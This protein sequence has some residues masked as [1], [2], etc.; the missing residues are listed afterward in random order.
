[1]RNSLLILG[2]TEQVKCKDSEYS[3][4]NRE[5]VDGVNAERKVEQYST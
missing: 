5:C 1:M 3:G 4:V 2:K